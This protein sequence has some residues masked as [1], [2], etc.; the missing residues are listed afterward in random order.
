MNGRK[1]AASG[2]AASGVWNSKADN[3]RDRA[4]IPDE[5][6]QT[7]RSGSANWRFRPKAEADVIPL[8]VCFGEMGG[9]PNKTSLNSFHLRAHYPRNFTGYR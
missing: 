7:I 6:C 9:N 5:P 3:Q 2:P 8:A 1:G 4:E